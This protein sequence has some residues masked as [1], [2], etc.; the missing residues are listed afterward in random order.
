MTPR[1]AEHGTSEARLRAHGLRPTAQR[2]AV[3]DELVREPN[4]VT[5]QEL[6]DRLRRRRKRIGLATVYRTLDSLVRAGVIETL[7]HFRDAV[8]YRVCRDGH[9]HHLVCTECHSVVELRDCD[10]EGPLATAAAAHG[11]VATAH[12]LEVTGVCG[13]CGVGATRSR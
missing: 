11:F 4:D 8:C 7:A 12:H 6:W 10:L 5:A 3:L 13:A 2:V 1:Q 9:H